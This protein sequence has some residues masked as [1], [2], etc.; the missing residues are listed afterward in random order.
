[1][2]LACPSSVSFKSFQGLK[3]S[4]AV[5]SQ[6]R[7][8]RSNVAFPNVAS[9]RLVAVA[10]VAEA[11]AAA[12]PAVL[13]VLTMDGANSGKTAELNLRT[14][15][16]E[17]AKAVVH[18][19]V[20]TYMQNK[21]AGTAST[22]TRAEVRGGG[23]KPMKQKG[24]GSA[25]RGSQRTPLRPGGGVVFGPKPKDWTIKI[26]KK[27][28][29]LAVGTA[30]QNAATANDGASFIVIE[31]VHDKVAAPKTKDFVAALA[32][33]GVDYK[34]DHALLLTG[35]ASENLLLSTRNIENLKVVT[36]NA[37]NI[38]DV[39]RADKLLVTESGLE[40]LNQRFGDDLVQTCHILYH[41]L[42][43]PPHSPFSH[44]GLPLPFLLSHSLV[45]TSPLLPLAPHVRP[46]TVATLP[47]SPS[48]L[49]FLAFVSCLPLSP[50]L[51]RCTFS[52]LSSS[53]SLKL[54]YP[55]LPITSSPLPFHRL[56]YAIFSPAE[57]SPSPASLSPSPAS[58]AI[59]RLC[60][61]W[62]ASPSL[63]SCPYIP[64]F[65]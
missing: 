10:A 25:R 57:L 3:A 49:H 64:P 22:K 41:P 59:P 4:P 61:F 54:P 8:S 43:S 42:P 19:A 9:K 53:S 2:A 63:P 56:A 32:R 48:H 31:D 27:E 18:R 51:F 46:H 33:W 50:S 55:Q 23:R 5:S 36:P 24:T 28:K 20:V 17:T 11:P 29:L 60:A 35:E 1:M 52:S 14:A 16:P 26:N 6:A 30:L 40:Y 21:R 65:I 37:L 45:V 58:P 7:I 39:L 12:G 47:S 38:Y 13:P 62:Q 15:R 44:A 34:K